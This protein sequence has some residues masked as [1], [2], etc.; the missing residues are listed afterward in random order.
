LLYHRQITV[1]HLFIARLFLEFISVTL[2]FMTIYVVMIYFGQM[3]PPANLPMLYLGWTTLAWLAFAVALILGGIGEIIE[4]TERF[5]MVITYV[6]VP[7][8]GTF[9]M[10]AWIPASF[11]KTALLMPF[12]DT[13]E[14][15]RAGYF[16]SSVRTYFNI[17]YTLSCC[18]V[19][20]FFGLL[21]LRFVRENVEVE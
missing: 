10:V 11:R 13:T 5:V 2:S 19:L 17:P 21:I 18:M 1:L 8:S 20:T 14:M 7:L 16:G 9:F 4:F 15:I 3:H 12:L 6:L